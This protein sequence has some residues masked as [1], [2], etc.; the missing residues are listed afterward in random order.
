MTSLHYPRKSGS[1]AYLVK[2]GLAGLIKLSGERHPILSR[3]GLLL[4]FLPG[5]FQLPRHPKLVL[6]LAW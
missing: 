5:G 3:E 2:I 4:G 6:R 1:V